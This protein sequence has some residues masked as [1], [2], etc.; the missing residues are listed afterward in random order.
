MGY[1]RQLGKICETRDHKGIVLRLYEAEILALFKVCCRLKLN[2]YP[3]NL[4]KEILL[5]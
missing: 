4:W 1:P 3:V 5:L 2:I